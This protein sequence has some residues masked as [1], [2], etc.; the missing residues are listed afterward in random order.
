MDRLA[1]ALGSRTDDAVLERDALLGALSAQMLGIRLLQEG[2]DAILS[3]HDEDGI[4]L[5]D[6]Q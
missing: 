1:V 4:C 5:A 3:R 6:D 2:I